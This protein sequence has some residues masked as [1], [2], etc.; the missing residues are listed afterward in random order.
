MALPSESLSLEAE[1][2]EGSGKQERTRDQQS[3][4][5]GTG[6]KQGAQAILRAVEDHSRDGTKRLD[7]PSVADCAA[8]D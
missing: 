8:L 1:L 4:R 6:C 3:G 5:E 7:I 2:L